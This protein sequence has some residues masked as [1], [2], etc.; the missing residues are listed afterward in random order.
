MTKYGVKAFSSGAHQIALVDAAFRR[1]YL[2]RMTENND[3]DTTHVRIRWRERVTLQ[4]GFFENKTSISIMRP[5]FTRVTQAFR[6]HI[7]II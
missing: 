7:C 4:E 2:R 5:F 3:Y 1:Q 6:L